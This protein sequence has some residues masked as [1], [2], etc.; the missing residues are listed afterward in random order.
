[1]D[2]MG[3]VPEHDG[4]DSAS[5]SRRGIVHETGNE[6]GGSYKGP[7]EVT[8]TGRSSGRTTRR[9]WG[10]GMGIGRR[11]VA[12]VVGRRR[13]VLELSR[14]DASTRIHH[15][16]TLATR[17]QRGGQHRAAD[18]ESAETTVARAEG[19]DGHEV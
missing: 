1:M 14:K 11:A 9:L 10:E 12:S 16:S 7:E 15:N 3:E 18:V 2:E 8:Q 4:S 13:G 17:K 19:S 6:L 5:N